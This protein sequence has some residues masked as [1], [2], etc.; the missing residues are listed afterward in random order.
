[1]AFA[2]SGLKRVGSQNSVAPTL[3]MYATADALTTI[4]TSG[5]F[6]AAANRLQAGDWILCS[7]TTTFGIFIVDTNT[8]DL[9]AVPPVA[10]VV[11]VKNAVSVGTID[12]D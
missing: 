12:S 7:S 6:N 4:D 3:W 9:D 10:G 5:Y 1:M 2:L 8:R 11:D